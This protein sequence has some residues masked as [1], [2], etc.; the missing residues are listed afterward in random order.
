LHEI[1]LTIFRLKTPHDPERVIIIGRY[2]RGCHIVDVQKQFLV[3]LDLM[4]LGSMGEEFVDVLV[5]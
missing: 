3:V 1:I 2:W 5:P 4:R